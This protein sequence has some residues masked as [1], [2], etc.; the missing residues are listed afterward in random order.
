MNTIETQ[1]LQT[2]QMIH[3]KYDPT[4]PRTENSTHTTPQTSPQ[5][6]SSNTFQTREHTLTGSQF[7]ITTPPRQ[8]T[9]T[10]QYIP[11]QPSISQNTSTVLTMNT[12]Y[13]NQI[14]NATTS[15]T[16]SRPPLPLIQNT[17][18]SYNLTSTIF[19]SQPSSSTTQYNTKIQSSSTQFNTHIFSTTIQT[20]QH[21]QPISTRPQTNTLNVP[22]TSF[23]YNTT[24]AIPSS[25]IPLTTIK[26]PTYINS[27]AS[28]SE[29]IKPFDGLDHNYTP[30]EYLQHI[31][32]HV[33]F[34][35]GLQPTTAHESEFW[36]ARR[37]A[38]IQCSL[39]GT[40]LSWYFRLNDTNEQD[41]HAFVK[42]FKK[43][44]SSQRNTYYAQVEALSLVK[45]DN[46]T[47]RNFATKVQQLVEKGWCNGIA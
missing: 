21:I 13:T 17:P 10:I 9:Q 41:W 38:F 6:G 31:E 47:V 22:P 16:L 1:P 33:T 34:S 20:S 11:A 19:H 40:A 4:P 29:P 25:K 3:Q 35:L 45:K 8:S 39:T 32:A 18:L 23:N 5:Q 36:H 12:L 44:I 27:S 2:H 14:T 7:Q 24:H 30:E 42:A 46:E 37:M 15:H 28:I 26:T 43:Q